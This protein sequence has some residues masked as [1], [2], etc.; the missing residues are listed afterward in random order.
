MVS[1]AVFQPCLVASES[2]TVASIVAI[3]IDHGHVDVVVEEVR[4]IRRIIPN[5]VAGY[6]KESSLNSVRP[7]S[8]VQRDAKLGLYPGLVEECRV[9]FSGIRS[10]AVHGDIEVKVLSRLMSVDATS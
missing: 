6:S 5:D 10:V 7:S 2:L 8:V 9:V 4:Q 3:A 1:Y